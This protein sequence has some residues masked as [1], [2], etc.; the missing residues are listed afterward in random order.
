[1]HCAIISISHEK[2][3]FMEKDI[4]KTGQARVLAI[5]DICG[6]GKCSL[7]VAIPILSAAG[8]EACAMPTAVFS[9]HTAF[10]SFNCHDLTD[11]LIPMAEGIKKQNVHFDAIYTGYLA[12]GAQAEIVKNIISMLGD[13]QTRVIVDPAM[14][15]NGKL[16]SCLPASFPEDM[17]T[18]CCAASVITPNVTEALLLLGKST[19]K[20]PES[21]EEYGAL[22]ETLGK[23]TGA[24]VVLT[25][26][27][28]E[29]GQVGCAVWENEKGALTFV[30]TPFVNHGY[31]GTGDVFS[32]VLTAALLGGKTL[33]EATHIAAEF[34]H[35][36][37][38]DTAKENPSLWYG[39]NFEKHLTALSERIYR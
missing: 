28:I 19:D 16:Y 25:S 3:N 27:H 31:H 33:I 24:D 34:V 9:N 39:V 12:N 35:D 30:S 37:I 20:M 36:A 2:G 5:H 11:Y 15:D 18:L 29:G 32:S 17:K 6:I 21:P 38:A 13:T 10:T 23:E 8:I 14:A 26:A 22:A 1:M 4:F 7:T